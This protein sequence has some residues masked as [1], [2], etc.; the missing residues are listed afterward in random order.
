MPPS[1]QP[2]EQSKSFAIT[3]AASNIG[4]ATAKL[5]ARRGAL[6]SLADLSLPRLEAARSS[7]G[8]DN[9]RHI[10]TAVDV[11]SSSAVSAWI[12]DT[13]KWFGGLDGCVNVAGFCGPHRYIVMGVNAT[14]AFNCTRAALSVMGAGGSLVNVTSAGG[15]QGLVGMG[16]Y[17]ASKHAVIGLSK[18]AAKEMGSKNVRVN[19]VA[20]S[21]IDTPMVKD[22]EASIGT[23]LTA[24]HQA[25]DRKAD[26][27][28]VANVIEFL[29]S[30]E[31][32]FVTGAVYSV[33][34][35]W[36]A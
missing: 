5:L 25:L 10:I 3:S 4:L 11:K 36:M 8:G 30:D 14:G 15:L 32:S 12:Q 35:G 20:P 34:G 17:C 29:L 31:A 2:V 21:T 26:P 6:L 22:M 1:S 19:C 23:S 16:A 9:E 13:V 24:S 18:T 27:S 33:A 7:L 28:E